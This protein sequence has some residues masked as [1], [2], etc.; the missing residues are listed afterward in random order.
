[1]LTPFIRPRSS[2]LL[3]LVCLGALLCALPMSAQAPS[4][5]YQGELRFQ[6][7]IAQGEFDFRF[8]LFDA[9]TG[10]TQI[11]T[12]IERQD[13]EVRDGLF[14]VPLDVPAAIFDGTPLWLEIR[15]REG[16]TIGPY[17]TLAPRRPLGTKPGALFAPLAENTDRLDGQDADDLAVQSVELV[18]TTL[19]ITEGVAVFDQDL[20]SLVSDDNDMS[21]TDELN[22]NLALN[23]STVEV[24]DAGGTLGA[25][26]SVITDGIDD[27]DADPTNEAITSAQLAG[28]LLE[29][30]ENGEVTN[31]VDLA[32]LLNSGLTFDGTTLSLTDGGGTL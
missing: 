29:L 9:P 22:T 8:V 18:G 15:V 10:G 32:S 24:T 16:G 1:M 4:L 28:A 11:G 25:D 20:S 12:L 21:P 5:T 27:A 17:Q 3:A 7:D 6:D 31:V 14:T 26:V 2:R 30:I 23:G 13:V 19:R